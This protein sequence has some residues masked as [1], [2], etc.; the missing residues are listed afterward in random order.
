M[1]CPLLLH[2]FPSNLA[3]MIVGGDQIPPHELQIFQ[4]VETVLID[5]ECDHC[6]GN[7]A[8]YVG[9]ES[10]VKAP[11]SFEPVNGTIKEK[12]SGQRW[13]NY[14]VNNM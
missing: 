4:I 12:V 9:S 5:P 2:W 3:V 11:P 10:L 8:G 7:D 6:C 1:P 14:I 13:C